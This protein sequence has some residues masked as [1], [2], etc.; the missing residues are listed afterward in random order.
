M[1]RLLFRFLA[2]TSYS[3]L[4]PTEIVVLNTYLPVHGN[5]IKTPLVQSDRR[6][7]VANGDACNMEKFCKRTYF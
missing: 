3:Y 4:R 2:T 7:I 5:K 6:M 1:I